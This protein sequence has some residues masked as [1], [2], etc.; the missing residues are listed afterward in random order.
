LLVLGLIVILLVTYA[1]HRYRK[2]PNSFEKA[3]KPDGKDDDKH[4]DSE[5]LNLNVKDL[6]TEM[7]AKHAKKIENNI[8]EDPE[9]LDSNE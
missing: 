6:E 5:E 4:N 7:H 3:S 2:L 1:I 8:V 9:K